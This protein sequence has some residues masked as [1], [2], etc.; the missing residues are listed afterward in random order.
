MQ[1]FSVRLL[2]VS[3][4]MR[5]PSKKFQARHLAAK[6]LG[7]ARRLFAYDPLSYVWG[8][9]NQSYALFLAGIQKSNHAHVD[10]CDLIQVQHNLCASRHLRLQLIEMLRSNPANKADDVVESV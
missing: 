2:L 3:P 9:M 10:Q 4:V 5:H 1:C 7:G 6:L 8:T